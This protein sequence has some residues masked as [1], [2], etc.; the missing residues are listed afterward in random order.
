M[1]MHRFYLLTSSLTSLFVLPLASAQKAVGTTP[2]TAKEDGNAISFF[3]EKEKQKVAVYQGKP[4]PLPRADI[5]PAFLRGG[6]VRELYSPRGVLLTDDY[7]VGHV[8]HHG[9]WTAWTKTKFHNRTPDFWNMGQEKGR[10]D[11]V[12]HTLSEAGHIQATMRAIDMLGK[13]EVTAAE[14]LWKLTIG[15]GTSPVAHHSVQLKSTWTISGEAALELPQYHY[16]GFGFRGNAQ[17]NGEQNLRVLTSNGTTDRVK[18]NTEKAKW[19]WLGGLVDG[20]LAG[21]LILDH[22]TN[23]RHPQPMRVH[24]KE[25]FFCYAP[26]QG[27]PMAIQPG[28]PY[29]MQ[30]GVLGVDGEPDKVAFEALWTGFAK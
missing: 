4:G 3:S 20:R 10:M 14:E 5:A 26:Q 2:V 18:A 13:P 12:S 28:K 27:G 24:P 19:C 7:A 17:W 9:I 22:S 16:G 6:Y 25:P 30:Y 23:F 15:V 1:A 11:Y 29:E 21:V 8:H